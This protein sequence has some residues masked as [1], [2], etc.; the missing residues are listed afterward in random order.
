MRD[1][2]PEVAGEREGAYVCVCEREGGDRGRGVEDTEGG[3]REEG[4]E[5]MREKKK[6][7]CELVREGGGEWR[8]TTG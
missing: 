2:Q 4:R 5:R 1:R 3:E 8:V 6:N 7:M